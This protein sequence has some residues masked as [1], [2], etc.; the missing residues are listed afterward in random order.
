MT[1]SHWAL[2]KLQILSTLMIIVWLSY[3]VL[4]WFLCCNRQSGRM[5]HSWFTSCLV[6][7]SSWSPL[8]IPPHLSVI[9][10]SFYYGNFYSYAKWRSIMNLHVPIL[11]LH[12]YLLRSNFISLM[13]L[14]TS[15]HPSPFIINQTLRPSFWYHILLVISRWPKALNFLHNW[16]KFITYTISLWLKAWLVLL[17]CLN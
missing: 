3:K 10:F 17:P 13:L 12:N 16:R 9:V 4:G 11:Q 6:V 5:P 14:P 8:M 15:L 7:T 1:G 2:P